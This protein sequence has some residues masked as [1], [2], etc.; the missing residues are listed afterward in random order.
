MFDFEKLGAFYLGR[1]QDIEVD[2]TTDET[3]LYDAKDLTTHALCV[4]MTGDGERIRRLRAAADFAIYTPGSN[5]GLPLTVLRSF[6]APSPEPPGR[7]RTSSGPGATTRPSSR[8]RWMGS[9]SP[10]VPMS[11]SSKR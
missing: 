4:G 8:R 5:V 3:I 9:S 10:C 2:E 1:R 6:D 7:K 11:W